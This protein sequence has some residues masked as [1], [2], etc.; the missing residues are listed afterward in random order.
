MS[1]MSD[2][3]LTLG[4]LA[5][6]HREVIVPDVERI[7][8][9]AVSGSERRLTDHIERLWDALLGTR[10][11]LETEYILIKS[12]IARVEGQL[13]GIDE[14][15]DRMDE[16]L[17]TLDAEHTDLVASV[18]RLEERLSRI[19]RQLDDLQ[20]RSVGLEGRFDDLKA[21]LDALRDQILA[22]EKRLAERS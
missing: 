15:L 20:K 6:F 9:D 5:K 18:L 14:H 1:P 3:P 17:G 10:E 7:V 16:R 12:G 21:R 11:R 22:V 4:V 13:D 8:S 2:E 19:E